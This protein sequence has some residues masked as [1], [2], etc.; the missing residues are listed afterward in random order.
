MMTIAHS[1]Q[2]PP[3]PAPAAISPERPRV[4]E[5]K[6]L[7]EEKRE[8]AWVELALRYG[9]TFRYQGSYVTCDPQLV[10]ILFTRKVH[11]ERRSRSYKAMARLIPGAPGPLFMDGEE[12]MQRAKT[13]L[14][15]FH[16]SHVQSLPQTI[17]ETA[18]DYASSWRDGERIED[19]FTEIMKLG[20]DV[21]LRAGLGLD[22][23]SRLARQLGEE[24]MRY[25]S[26]TMGSISRLDEFGFSLKQFLE[27]PTFITG[28]VKLKSQ[29]KR[30][31]MLVHSILEERGIVGEN[32]WIWLL[33]EA[34]YSEREITNTVN[35]LYGAYN[36]SDFSV[37]C[38]LYELSRRPE[39]AEILRQEFDAALGDKPH[40]VKEDFPRLVNTTCFM[41]EVFRKY[42]VAMAV[43][44]QTGEPIE[45][46]G[47]RVPAGA[48]VMILLY[49]LHHHP[50]FWEEPETFD[51]LR[52][53]SMT[54]PRVPFSYLPFLTGARQC[55]GRHLAEMTFVAILHALLRHYEF[56]VLDRSVRMNRYMIPRFDRHIP[57]AIRGRATRTQ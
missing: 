43:M 26:H 34:G 46:T 21:A 17:H 47:G 37:T 40:P 56:D 29:M 8:K 28:L 45:T 53:Q 44:R 2:N 25:K 23:Q 20:V 30:I 48:E 7:L 31:G 14:P 27:L 50:D 22:P 15:A 3:N 11:A 4:T 6:R 33:Q 51:P 39:W 9:R 1:L 10:E 36:A 38:A 49:A 5:A 13:L 52:W 42:P 16:G 19:L 24:L 32:G 18:L 41:K 35:H 54:T 12:W 57:C 55:L